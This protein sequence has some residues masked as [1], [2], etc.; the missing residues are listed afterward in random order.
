MA[1]DDAIR[2]AS[3]AWRG[4]LRRSVGM[5]FAGLTLV[6]ML[7]ACG[8][9]F[10]QNVG[11]PDVV[12]SGGLDV[13][14]GPLSL[15]VAWSYDGP[16]DGFLISRVATDRP[17]ECL[18][19]RAIAP[20]AAADAYGDVVAE[21]DGAVRSWTD[22]DVDP[23]MAYRYYLQLIQGRAS[24]LIEMSDPRAVSPLPAD[25]VS[26][27]EREPNDT[28]AQAQ[29]IG[30]RTQ[31]I[32]ALASQGDVDSFVFEARAGDVIT[33]HARTSSIGSPLWP[34]LRLY[35][36]E[37]Q[38]LAVAVGNSLT[39]DGFVEEA[40]LAYQAEF[41]GRHVLKVDSVVGGQSTGAYRLTIDVGA[42][43]WALRA[44][45]GTFQADEFGEPRRDGQV[46]VDVHDGCGRVPA[47]SFTARIDGPEGWNGGATV[48]QR[49]WY[50]GYAQTMRFPLDEDVAVQAPAVFELSMLVH[51]QE[52]H[53]TFVVDPAMAIAAPVVSLASVT[54]ERV[55][56]RWDPV[57]GAV[58]YGAALYAR[59]GWGQRD[60]VARQSWLEDTSVRFDGLALDPAGRYELLVSAGVTTE[61]LPGIRERG[62][63]DAS[64]TQLL[65]ELP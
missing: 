1:S 63:D 61:G 41:D 55:H 44:V 12:V 60:L 34:T 18:V 45:G 57:P 14:P 50:S 53:T 58:S 19:D 17:D 46:V 54:S 3:A 62:S 2:R 27:A 31:V 13:T 6:A 29:P 30:Y 37:E 65:F 9:G 8:D 38:R 20:V 42:V 5:V 40:Y 23:A 59:T 52:L 43:E 35:D 47:G 32:G 51:G 21:V 48:E 15:T 28:P 49:L 56:A 16:A 7:M 11:A 33:I 4:G 10:G 39:L 36:E 26:V 24:R 22:V 25:W 64:R